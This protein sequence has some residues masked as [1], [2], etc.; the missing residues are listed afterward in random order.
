MKKKLSAVLLAGGESTRFWPLHDK[1]TFL[2]LGKPFLFWHY[3]QLVQSGIE[4]CIVVANENTQDEIHSVSVPEGMNVTYV[5]QKGQGMGHAV[6]A[7]DGFLSE[8]P[9]LI[10]NASDYY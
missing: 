7:L 9:I 4:K 10:L 6:A 5:V 3:R 2:F 8:D 1:N